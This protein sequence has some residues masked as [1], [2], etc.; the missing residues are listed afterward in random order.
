MSKLIKVTCSRCNGSGKFSFNLV[1][2]TVCFLC[3]GVGFKMVDAAKEARRIAAKA[4]RDTINAATYE[5]RMKFAKEV[6]LELDAEFGP[7]ADT[8]LGAYE[9]MRACQVAYGG[10][11]PGALVSER[12][13][14]AA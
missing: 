1:R 11:T 3:E 14:A 5:I 10:K 9:R 8:E 6:R 2:G 7:F 4:K 12:M 13:L